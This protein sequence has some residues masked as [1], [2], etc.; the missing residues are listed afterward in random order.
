MSFII[1]EKFSFYSYFAENFHYES[2]LKMSNAFSAPVEVILGFLYSVNKMN[3]TDWFSNF[4]PSWLSWD[5]SH[6]V[7]V[8]YYLYILLLLTAIALRMFESGFL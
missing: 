2:I 5:K 8:Y 1:L 7:M 6:L 4:K 3:Y